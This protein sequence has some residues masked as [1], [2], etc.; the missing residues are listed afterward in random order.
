MAVD[1]ADSVGEKPGQMTLPPDGGQSGSA[2]TDSNE[3]RTSFGETLD[4]A[5]DLST[6]H[7]GE[8][9]AN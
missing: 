1:I 9:L 4:Q 6:W 7:H 5:L 8:D 2:L 3:F